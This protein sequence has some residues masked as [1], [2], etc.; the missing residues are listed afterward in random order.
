MPFRWFKP[1]TPRSGNR[2]QI[3]GRRLHRRN[4]SRQL[5]AIHD[6]SSFGILAA[7][8]FDEKYDIERAALIPKDIVLE[9]SSFVEQ[10]NSYKFILADNVWEEKKVTDVTG[11][12]RGIV[13]RLRDNREF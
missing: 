1:Q 3:K 13:T 6:F 8:L 7:V 12:L 4:K 9:R 10:T 2:Y 11:K 5:S